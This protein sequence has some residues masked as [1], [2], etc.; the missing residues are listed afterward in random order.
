MLTTKKN[1]L[2]VKWWYKIPFFSQTLPWLFELKQKSILIFC[3]PCISIY[4][5]INIKQLDALNFIISSFMP[6][7]VSSTC[8][9]RQFCPPDDE[10][11]CSKHVEAW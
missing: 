4:L 8:A 11:M 2:A 1:P 5:F 9:D 6:L 7:H 3:W 10:H